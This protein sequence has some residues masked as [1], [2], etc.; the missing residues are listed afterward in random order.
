MAICFYL[1]LVLSLYWSLQATKASA[2]KAA[3]SRLSRAL[4]LVMVN[5]A[6]LLAFW[7]Y[8]GWPFVTAPAWVFPV[9]F[10]ATPALEVLGV[11]VQ[12]GCLLL[13]LWARRQLGRNW[14]GEVTLKVDHELVRSGPYRRIRH[15]IYTGAIG[16]YIGPA[17]ISGRL[18]GILSVA[19]VA[20]AYARKIRQEERVLAGEFGQAYDAYRRESWAL[21]PWLL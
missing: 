9:V 12:A 13:A 20:I 4:H 5:G 19:L 18:Q 16:M 8:P 2:A 3:E 6:F 15:P 10:P 7:P 11:I 17:L 21:V 1:W 14:S